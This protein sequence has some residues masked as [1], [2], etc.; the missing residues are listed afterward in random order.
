MNGLEPRHVGEAAER[1][2]EPVLRSTPGQ[3]ERSRWM[4]RSLTRTL[5][6]GRLERELRAI[7]VDL[8][9]RCQPDELPHD[10]AAWLATAV[11]EAVTRVCGSSLSALA[12]TLDA[13]LEAAPP[14]I[15]RR[16]REA[17]VRH[18]AGYV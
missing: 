2:H 3:P 8:L 17:E 12:E 4:V 16:L 18:D 10:C 14:W 9:G 11:E 6:Q 5:A 1:Q 13:R 7:A 15:A